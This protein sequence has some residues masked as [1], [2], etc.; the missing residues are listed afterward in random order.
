M[1]LNGEKNGLPTKMPVAMIDV[2][3]GHQLKEGLLVG[4]IEKN[5]NRRR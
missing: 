3:A 4:V 5:K 1:D 2:L